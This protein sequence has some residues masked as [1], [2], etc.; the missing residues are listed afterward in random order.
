MKRILQHPWFPPAALLALMTLVALPVLTYPMGRDQGMYAIIGR[1]ILNGQIPFIDFWDI[2]PPPIYYIY[3]AG[4]GIFG[5]G[6]A[7]LRAIDLV[8]VPLTCAALYWLGVRVG[9]RRVGL[10]AIV[11]F[12]AFYFT[13]TFASLTQSDSIVTLPMTLAVLCVIKAGDSPRAGRSALWWSFAAGLLSAATLWFKQYYAL[14][15]IV[16]VL[17]H[18]LTRRAIPVKEALSFS[19]GGLLIGVGGLIYF[20]ALGIIN[21]MVVVMQSTSQ[22]N[23]Q[24]YDFQNFIDSMRNYV[25]WRWRHWGV[26][27]VLAA[28]WPVAA[29][30]SGGERKSGW[31]LI[32][33][34]M[35]AGLLAVLLQA[36]GF[37]THWLPMLPPLA[38]M[39]AFSTSWLLERLLTPPPKSDKVRAVVYGL[40][41]VLLTGIL[42]RGMWVRAWPYLTGAESQL[43]YYAHFQAN[44]LK[45][46]ESLEMLD[47]LRGQM[48]PGSSLFVWGFRPEIYYLGP[49]E[50]ATRF[51]AHFPL[52][53]AWYPPEWRDEAVADLWA[54]MPP[55]VL[56]LQ[57]D[58]MPW[59][60]GRE[61][62]SH[63]LLVEYTG[64]SDWLA[65]NYERL[66]EAQVGNFI[67]WRRVGE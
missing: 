30:L 55:Y 13:E 1:G 6:S 20:G 18:I 31:Q 65:A 61:E 28:L 47:Y 48:P 67:V 41:M 33:L 22:Y 7:A 42:I 62:D 4:I 40:A 21:E 43:E 37:D 23:A 51:I 66:W 17:N 8:T 49:Y 11:I 3:A 58:Y 12:Y 24:G 26:M 9:N 44:D 54:T 16:L 34:W 52:V 29:R 64:L 2:K 10:L 60:T 14:F 15:V 32:I 5:P 56:V 59:V 35:L 27:L 38:L 50:P 19:A 53:A 57:A 45:P 36:L 46:A 39:A 63:Q 25:G